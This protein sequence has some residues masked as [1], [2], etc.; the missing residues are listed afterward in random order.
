MFHVIQ[1]LYK[2]IKSCVSLQEIKSDYFNVYQGVRQG[3]NLSPVLFA[4][5]VDDLSDFLLEH[6]N[7]VLDFNDN[8]INTYLQL[9][10]LMYAD[11]TVIMT[12]NEQ[13]LQ[14]A[15]LN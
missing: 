9:F 1:C 8:D 13:Q 3:E 5:F 14:L 15:L 12:K 2:N 11:D 6:N 7:H 10:I 4:L